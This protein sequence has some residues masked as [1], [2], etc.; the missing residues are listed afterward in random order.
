MWI[1]PPCVLNTSANNAR[2]RTLVSLEAQADIRTIMLV[3]S[4]ID[5]KGILP[6]ERGRRDT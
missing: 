2:N 3:L 6:K 5:A 1:D 4:S